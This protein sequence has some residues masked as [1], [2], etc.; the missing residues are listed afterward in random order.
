MSVNQAQIDFWNG[1]T[2]QKWAR[3]QTDMDR[4][5]ADIGAAVMALA[6]A[7]SGERVLDIGCGNGA[8]SLALLD[9]VGP[10]GDVTGVDVSQP[11][12]AIART[13]TGAANVH[14]IE[15]DAS[16]HPFM[17]DRDLIFSRFGVMFFVE[18]AAAFANIRKAAAKGGRLAFVCWRRMEENEW[19]MLPWCTAKPFLPEQKQT[20]PDAP[21][22]FAFADKDRT[23]A[24]L[25]EAG[26]HGIAIEAFNGHMR[27]GTSAEHAA[28]QLTS[29][30]GPTSRAL[31]NVDET[32]RA[33]VREAI[34][35]DMAAFQ[36]SAPEIAPGTAC[37]LVSAK[38]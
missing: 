16:A 10:S 23:H 14:F 3:H 20:D 15:A 13:R 27:L 1:P 24:I 9:A 4:N 21:G 31:K 34:A 11:M 26:F 35:S 33:K 19:T 25:A 5:L 17:P 37:W 2:G 12:L 22:P 36:G 8:T 38:A 28:L 6:D 7:R 32:T 18:P 29:L 30:M